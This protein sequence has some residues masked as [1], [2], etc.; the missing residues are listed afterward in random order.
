MSDSL[1]KVKAEVQGFYVSSFLG[2]VVL[3]Y[4]WGKSRCVCQPADP[5]IPALVYLSLPVEL[6]QVGQ[7][8]EATE[9]SSITEEYIR[10]LELL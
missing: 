4:K 1:E 6:V 3:N 8:L 5:E 7:T 2:Q 10:F 9:S